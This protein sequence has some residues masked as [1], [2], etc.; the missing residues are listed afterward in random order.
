[1]ELYPLDARDIEAIARSRASRSMPKSV[2][3]WLY[4]GFGVFIVGIIYWIMNG[5][6]VALGIMV[7][8]AILAW[9][10]TSL[11]DKRRKVVIFELKRE[12]RE[13]QKKQ[14]ASKS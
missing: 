3:N 7:V 12:W 2:K 4:G 11:S 10:A 13:E 1:M 9:Y 14:E 8:G 5:G 6:W